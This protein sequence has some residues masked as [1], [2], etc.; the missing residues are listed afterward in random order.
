MASRTASRDLAPRKG[1]ILLEAGFDELTASIG[2]RGLHTWEGDDRPPPSIEGL[3]KEKRLNAG[4]LSRSCAD[5]TVVTLR[6]SR[7]IGEMRSGQ[8]G[9]ALTLIRHRGRRAAGA[10]DQGLQARGRQGSSPINSKR[11]GARLLGWEASTGDN[12][13][14]GCEQH[15]LPHAGEGS[16]Y[17][18]D[19]P[20]C[21][22][23]NDVVRP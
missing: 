16:G 8:D 12:W 14:E 7:M 21:G 3:I 23:I 18:L 22:T 13:H 5:G 19:R 1:T 6:Q 11:A 17:V 4:E 15:P 20:I 9:F 2:R 10:G